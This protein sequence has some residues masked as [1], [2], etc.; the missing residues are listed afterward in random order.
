MMDKSRKVIV[1]YNDENGAR[2]KAI[3]DIPSRQSLT[4]PDLWVVKHLFLKKLASESKIH[5]LGLDAVRFDQVQIYIFDEDFGDEFLMTETYVIPDRAKNLIAK[6]VMLNLV[7]AEDGTQSMFD[8]KL[9]KRFKFIF[10]HT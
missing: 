2:M 5:L 8:S 1:S 10:F 7:E 9:L 6:V 3:V 4:D